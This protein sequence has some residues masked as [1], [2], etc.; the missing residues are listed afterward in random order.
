LNRGQTSSRISVE[1]FQK[2]KSQTFFILHEV[3]H[4]P[5]FAKETP[6][7]GNLNDTGKWLSVSGCNGGLQI[8]KG[9]NI[10]ASLT[11]STAFFRRA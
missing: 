4:N 2:P 7:H 6:V 8:A 9:Q 10:A 11:I 1:P 5:Y 3:M